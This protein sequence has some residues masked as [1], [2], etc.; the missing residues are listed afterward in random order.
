MKASIVLLLAP[1][2]VSAA[3]VVDSLEP[4]QAAQSI[5]KLFKAKG[6][7][8]FG[9]CTD[10]GRLTAGKNAAIIEANFGQVTPE[11]SMKWESINSQ[12]GKYNWA[13][14]DYL[15]DWATQRNKTIRGHTF[16]WH[17]QLAGWVNNIRDKA[18]LTK[19]IEEHI[20]TVMTRYKGKIHHWVC[21][22]LLFPFPNEAELTPSTGRHQRNVQRR[23]LPPQQ[24]LLQ[25]ARRGLRGHRVPGRARR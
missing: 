11:N 21:L 14:A 23:R 19:A 20:T 4:R 7:E 9:T 10:Q 24:R 2:A 15:V 18:T 3:P 12:Q 16:V 5:D 6:K 17:S 25:R 1:L 22:P 8:Y 13:Q